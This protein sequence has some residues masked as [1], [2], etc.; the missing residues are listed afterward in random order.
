MRIAMRQ[1]CLR[2]ASYRYSW[3]SSVIMIALALLMWAGVAYQAVV[4]I[5]NEAADVNP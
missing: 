2:A 1:R 4:A 3:R 5:D